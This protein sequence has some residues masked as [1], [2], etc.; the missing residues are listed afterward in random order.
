MGY[1]CQMFGETYDQDLM[2]FEANKSTTGVTKVCTDKIVGGQILIDTP[3]TNDADEELSDVK[4]Q[5]MII[6]AL[7]PIICE[8]QEGIT[9]FV[10][11]VQPDN[12]GRIRETAI[13]SM[14]RM[15]LS[16]NFFYEEAD[17]K[18]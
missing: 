6:N 12:S 16:L 3:G 4:I 7:H 10:N 1:Y 5:V 11:C 2:T 15:L 14:C 8:N 18:N 17:F 9:T 13:Q